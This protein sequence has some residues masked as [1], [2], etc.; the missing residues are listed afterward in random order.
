MNSPWTILWA[1][2]V[3]YLCLG[4]W[5]VAEKLWHAHKLIQFLQHSDEAI[6]VADPRPT[7]RVVG[8]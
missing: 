1:I 4:V 7:F 6:E 2:P 3:V 5:M 8:K